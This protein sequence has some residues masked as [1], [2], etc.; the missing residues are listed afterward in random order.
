M[1]LGSIVD[2]A[3]IDVE[4]I[5]RRLRQQRREGTSA[6]VASIIL[7]ASLEIRS[8]IVYA[9][10]IIVLA[11]TPVF[12]MGGLSGAFLEPLAL[13]YALALLASMVVAL[14][15]TPAL[16]LILLGRA[17]ISHASPFVDMLQRGYQAALSRIIRAPRATF[18]VSGLDRGR[19]RR[20]LAVP[21]TLA[22]SVVQ[23]ARFSDALAHAARNLASGDVSGDRS[24]EPRAQVHSRRAQ[25]RRPYREGA[26]RGRAGRHRL[27][28]ELISV[29]P[30][31]DYDKT[32][33]AVQ[34]TVG[35]YPDLSRRPDLSQGAHQ[36]GPDWRQRV[37]RRAHL[38]PGHP[39]A[40]RTGGAGPAGTDRDQGPHRPAR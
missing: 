37:D 1:A 39:G 35:G 28:R 36:G 26:R 11:V 2:D 32:L 5:V 29:D 31:V 27:H 16:C 6:S 12:F 4:N 10:L 9:T 21:R 15:V 7:K 25:L 23:G 30:N 14:T 22:A 17:E 13:S 19:R 24:G 38:R 3:I 18:V 20:R 34:E 8:A 33:S 40:A